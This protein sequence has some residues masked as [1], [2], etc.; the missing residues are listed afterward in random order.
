M[1]LPVTGDRGT[2]TTDVA[3]TRMMT[4]KSTKTLLEIMAPTAPFPSAFSL[5]TTACDGRPF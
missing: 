3:L 2:V 5:Q 1:A 4:T